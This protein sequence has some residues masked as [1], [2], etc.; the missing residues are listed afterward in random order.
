MKE[1]YKRELISDL[2]PIRFEILVKPPIV[3]DL[4]TYALPSQLTTPALR[5]AKFVLVAELMYIL[6][7]PLL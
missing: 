1:M 6:A 3:L 5:E 2:R 4:R 7:L